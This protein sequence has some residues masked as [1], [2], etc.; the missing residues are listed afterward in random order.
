[1]SMSESRSLEDYAPLLDNNFSATS[2]ANDL[3]LAT[4]PVHH[5]LDISTAIKRVKFDI[6]DINLQLEKISS[7]NHEALI[8]EIHKDQSIKGL[9]KDL[10]QPLDHINTSYQRLEKDLVQPYTEATKTQDALKK[11]HTTSYLL[12]SVTY[13]LYLIGQIESIHS[14]PSFEEH[15]KKNPKT[16]IKACNFHNQLKTHLDENVNLKSLKIIRDYEMIG[17]K[18]QQVLQEFIQSH[19]K[20]LNER[21]ITQ[22]PEA[23]TKTFI[24][25]LY[26]LDP[27]LLSS[28]IKTVLANNVVMSV[29]LLTRVLNS[30]RN[31]DSAL[32]DVLKKAKFIVKFS[33]I[34]EAAQTPQSTSLL[35]EVLQRLELTSLLSTFWRD[36]AKTFEVKFSETMKRG[37]P[38]AKS[39]V[40][41]KDSIRTSIKRTVMA[42]AEGVIKPEGVEVKMM[43]NS[44]GSLDRTNRY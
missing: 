41:Y 43:L 10:S 11:I 15:L 35:S 34:L 14:N 7:E 3:L 24:L 1:M 9:F 2:F 37:G 32:T 33:S 27:E 20:S 38:V 12:R 39:L 13:F 21:T 8:Q 28:T 18:R 44:V 22:E 19:I 30:P 25:S 23:T 16:M 6:N 31:F 4:N 5:E 42:S 40:S 36:V 17:S 26:T 29:N